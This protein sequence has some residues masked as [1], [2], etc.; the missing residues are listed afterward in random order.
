MKPSHFVTVLVVVLFA[1]ASSSSM[2]GAGSNSAEEAAIAN[3]VRPSSI[4]AR[5]YLLERSL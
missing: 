2:R 1:I 4:H 3:W 5:Q